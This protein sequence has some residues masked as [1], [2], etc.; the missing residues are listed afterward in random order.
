MSRMPD[1]EALLHR[2]HDQSARHRPLQQRRLAG[3]DEVTLTITR[4]DT[5]VGNALE[6]GR[7][8][9]ARARR[10]RHHSGPPGDAEVDRNRRPAIRSRTTST[11]RSR[12]RTSP[13]STDPSN[14]AVSSAGRCRICCNVEGNYTFH[15]KAAVHAGLHRHARDHLVDPRR[16]RNRSR[17]DDRQHDAARRRAGRRTVRADDVHAARQVREHARPRPP[18]RIQ[19][20]RPAR[21]HTVGRGSRS[22]QR[23]LPGR[24]LLRSGLARAAVDRNRAAWTRSRGRSGPGIQAASSTA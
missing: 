12:C 14:R 4:P 2:R 10:R 9:A 23:Q 7:P 16:R 6:R 8:E 15:A 22:R 18:G 11:R 5:S 1:S 21:Q 13:A 3:R 24:C 20:R 19:G 17:Q